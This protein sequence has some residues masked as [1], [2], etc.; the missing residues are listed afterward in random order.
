MSTLVPDDEPKFTLDTAEL[1]DFSDPAVPAGIFHELMKAVSFYIAKQYN[2]GKITGT[3]YAT[4]FTQALESVLNQSVLI[5]LQRP[6]VE[7]QV[8]SEQMKTQLLQRQRDGFAIDFLLKTYGMNSDTFR[9]MIG[10]GGVAPD[11]KKAPMV[12]AEGLQNQFTNIESLLKSL[13]NGDNSDFDFP[14]SMG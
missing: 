14:V 2:E 11:D 8:K 4:V 10:Q 1:T 13:I 3:V 7:Q 12:S 9:V 5:F 6:L